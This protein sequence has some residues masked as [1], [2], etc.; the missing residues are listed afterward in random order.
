MFASSF[1]AKGRRFR[2]ANH[3]TRHDSRP[4]AITPEKRPLK[5]HFK[6][7][8]AGVEWYSMGSNPHF[9]GDCAFRI[10]LGS[11]VVRPVTPQG[12]DGD[13]LEKP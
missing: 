10:P 1:K 7:R 4:A 13:E 3:L 9:E 8:L 2:K 11:V 6:R 12:R 5:T